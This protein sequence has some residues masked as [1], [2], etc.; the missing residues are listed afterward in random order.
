MSWIDTKEGQNHLRICV[1]S[2]P[3]RAVE[4]QGAAAPKEEQIKRATEEELLKNHLR[5]CVKSCPYRVV[6]EGDHGDMTFLKGVMAEKKQALKNGGNNLPGGETE[7]KETAKLATHITI[8]QGI[9]TTEPSEA[10]KF[11]VKIEDFDAGK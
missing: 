9:S 10:L 11:E 4:A 8:V 7:S 5:I 2:C 1:E 6:E 3:Y